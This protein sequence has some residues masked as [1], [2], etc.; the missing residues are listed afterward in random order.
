MLKIMSS[1]QLAY[2]SLEVHDVP[3]RQDGTEAQ[4]RYNILK[5]AKIIL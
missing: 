1:S 2:I 5:S 3:T 4:A